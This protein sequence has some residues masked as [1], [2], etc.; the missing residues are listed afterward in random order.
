MPGGGLAE[1]TIRLGGGL[2]T[3]RAC[4]IVVQPRW[5]ELI[6]K[7]DQWIYGRLGVSR[8]LLASS[9]SWF[10]VGMPKLMSFLAAEMVRSRYA[11]ALSSSVS[12]ACGSTRVGPA[13]PRDMQVFSGPTEKRHPLR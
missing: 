2:L 5:N 11:E 13:K 7:G 12:F 1:L 3:C 4:P 10:F 9:L 8:Q 6:R